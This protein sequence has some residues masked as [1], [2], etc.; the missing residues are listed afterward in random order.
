VFAAVITPDYDWIV[1]R[2]TVKIPIAIYLGDHD[3]FFTVAQA[4]GTR[5]LLAANGFP[6]R[7]KIFPNLDHNYGAVADV[8]NPDVWSFFMQ[9]SPQ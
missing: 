9:A 1:Q 5:D 3:Q 8:V 7:L 6:V 2:A 4:Q